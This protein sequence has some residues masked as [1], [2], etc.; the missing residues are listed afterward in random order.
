MTLMHYDGGIKPRYVV[1]LARCPLIL[2]NLCFPH[3]LLLYVFRFLRFINEIVCMLFLFTLADA[4]DAE[5][6]DVKM[7]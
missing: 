7:S 3:L 1:L 4:F 2:A 6:D 5:G